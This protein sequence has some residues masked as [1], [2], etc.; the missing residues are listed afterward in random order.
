MNYKYVIFADFDEILKS[1]FTVFKDKG[2]KLF[3]IYSEFVKYS[4][5]I[6]KL[7]KEQ[8]LN[9]VENNKF[10]NAGTKNGTIIVYGNDDRFLEYKVL[11]ILLKAYKNGNVAV[12]VGDATK[13]PRLRIMQ[14]IYAQVGFSLGLNSFAA[15]FGPNAEPIMEPEPEPEVAP[16]KPEAPK[17]EE[18][19]AVII[20]KEEKQAEEKPEN[21]FVSK[22]EAKPEPKQ[23]EQPQEEAAVM[24]QEEEQPQQKEAEEKP[25]NVFVSKQEA[26]P[27]PKQEEQPQEEAVIQFEE[28]PQAPA[29]EEKPAQEQEE[30]QE[31]EEPKEDNSFVKKQE[32]DSDEESAEVDFDFKF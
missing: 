8:V 27:E 4:E 16:E 21:V 13:Y 24:L 30:Q 22:Q 25:E 29:Q 12:V 32:G 7:D 9:Y 19:A 3:F 26:K 28:K 5:Y 2:V 11:D 15:L 23:E 10:I 20:Q 6:A 14:N 18:E 17:Q 31:Q 1:D